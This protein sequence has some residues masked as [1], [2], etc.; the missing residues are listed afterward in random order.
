MNVPRIALATYTLL[1]ELDDDDAPLLDVLASRGVHAEAVVW[2]DP[3][4]DW[5][6]FDLVVIRNTWDYMDRLEEYLAWAERVSQVTTLANPLEV[7]RWNTDKIY[8]RELERHGVAVVPTKYLDPAEH[9]EGRK[10]HA[11]TPGRGQFVVKP[12]V[13]AGSKDTARYRSGDVDDRGQ[14]MRHTRRLLDDGRHVMIQPYLTAVDDVGETALIY[15]GGLFSHAV[16]KGA[17]LRGF[18]DPLDEPFMA[19]EMSPREASA[20]ERAVA[21]AVIEALPEL[22]GGCERAEFPLLY[23]RVDL[24]PDADGRPLVLEVEA[25]EPSLFFRQAPGTIERFADAIVGRAL[26]ARAS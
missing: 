11:R 14:A 8:L 26:A 12:T 5:G 21:D 22:V 17:I 15:V 16:R 18:G 25:T 13:S 9:N 2:D 1:P 4:V 20:A 19:E 24:V 6:A 3:A 7:V 23:V 10:I